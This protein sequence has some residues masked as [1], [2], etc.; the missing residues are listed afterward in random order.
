MM[1]LQQANTKRRMGRKSICRTTGHWPDG[2]C[3]VAGHLHHGH[4]IEPVAPRIRRTGAN[5]KIRVHGPTLPV[6]WVALRL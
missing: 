6:S 4:A 1:W 3:L 2:I 5:R